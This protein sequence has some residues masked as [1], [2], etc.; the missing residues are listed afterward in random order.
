MVWHIAKHEGS[1]MMIED[2]WYEK[3]KALFEKWVVEGLP[4]PDD[5]IT[6]RVFK[7][8]PVQ[9][10][11]HEGKMWAVFRD[12]HGNLYKEEVPGQAPVDAKKAPEKKEKW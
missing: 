5:N 10:V 1:F 6:N 2:A 11:S 4:V 8:E 12:I 3:N 7:P 9:I